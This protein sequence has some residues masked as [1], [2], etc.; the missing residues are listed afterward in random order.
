MTTT[1]HAVHW[2]CTFLGAWSLTTLAVWTLWAIAIRV[3]CWMG[4]HR[5]ETVRSAFGSVWLYCLD[6]EHQRELA[7]EIIFTPDRRYA[8][9]PNRKHNTNHNTNHNKRSAA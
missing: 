1:L 6:C 9:D 5:R 8:V 7:H 3:P 4:H 2:L